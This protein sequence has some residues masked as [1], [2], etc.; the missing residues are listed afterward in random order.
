M[1]RKGAPVRTTITPLT[2]PHDASHPDLVRY[3]EIM[4]A[5]YA[6]D[7][8]NGLLTWRPDVE[9]SRLRRQEHRV[10]R[11]FLARTGDEI[12]GAGSLEFER[13]TSRDVELMVSVDPARR[14]PALADALYERLE[15]EARALGRTNAIEYSSTATDVRGLDEADVIR[16]SSGIG[17]LPR[18]ADSV[19]L[20]LARG[21]SLGLVE[22]ASVH[23]LRADPSPIRAMLEAAE[24]TAGSDYEAVWWCG[25]TP[26]EYVD[27]YA[28]AIS[29]MSTDAPHGDIDVEEET[30]D[31]ARIRAREDRVA[32]ID[33]LW[34]IT[35]VV[36]RPSGRIVA[37][38]E[39]V[40]G[41]DR[42]DTTENYGTLVLAEHR[43]RR[44]GTIVKCLGLLKWREVAPDSPAVF[45]FNAEVNRYMLDV[46]E[47][48]GF[49]P[50]HWEGAWNKQLAPAV[51]A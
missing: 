5:S 18:A 41:A 1:T 37:F 49:V 22:R 38:N 45:T 43:G 11:V 4:N 46:N 27:A 6:H 10:V 35:A 33:Q 42:T 13:S 51:S 15:H 17:G 44:L 23:D 30:W 50:M 14:D 47:A 36:H 24:R 28:Y 25:R 3:V 34:G 26:D 32:S 9:L 20:L 48:A 40:L 8:G 29:R 2:A 39:L 21:Y 31:A 12:V 16:P 19:R 7:A